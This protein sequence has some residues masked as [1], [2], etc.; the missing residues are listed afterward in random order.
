MDNLT[1]LALGN[2]LRIWFT[3]DGSPA[4]KGV[5]ETEVQSRVES[6]LNRNGNHPQAAEVEQ[7]LDKLLLQSKSERDNDE[8]NEFVDTVLKGSHLS[9][10]LQ[11]AIRDVAFTVR[12]KTPPE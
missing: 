4:F 1:P 2:G 6:W 5:P 3:P 10:E 12:G 8:L 11:K 7:W 9:S